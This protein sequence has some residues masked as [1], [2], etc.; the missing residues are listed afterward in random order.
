MKTTRPFDNES[1]AGIQTGKSEDTIQIS[2]SAAS[3]QGQNTTNITALYK[4]AQAD[5]EISK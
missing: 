4:S 5:A 1:I 3:A 2:V